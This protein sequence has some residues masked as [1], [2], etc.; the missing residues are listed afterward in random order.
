MI[1]MASN[2]SEV[3][4]HDTAEA[5]DP[6][7]EA[8]VG[9]FL[10]KWK[11]VSGPKVAAQVD[12]VEQTDVSRWRR[13]TWTYLTEAKAQ[14]IRDD[15]KRTPERDREEK[16]I[17]ARWMRRMAEALELEATLPPESAVKTDARRAAAAV[18]DVLGQAPPDE[19]PP[20]VPP[21]KQAVGGRRRKRAS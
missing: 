21:P 2:S 9:V 3:K 15:L 4:G 6:E 16:L 14:A 19:A 11:G 7:S 17:A 10:E 20:E 1:R 5:R 8:L 13:G 18:L 12:G